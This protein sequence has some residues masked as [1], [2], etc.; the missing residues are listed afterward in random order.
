MFRLKRK[1]VWFKIKAAT[2]VISAATILPM[3]NLY[4]LSNLQCI[5]QAGM[6]YLQ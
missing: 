6:N 1:N 2:L 3:E 5:L 4:D